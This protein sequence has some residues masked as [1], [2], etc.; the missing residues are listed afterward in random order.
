M[1]YKRSTLTRFCSRLSANQPPYLSIPQYHILIL[2][3]CAIVVLYGEA[4]LVPRAL[5]NAV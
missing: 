1:T 5:A 2:A 4:G 3:W